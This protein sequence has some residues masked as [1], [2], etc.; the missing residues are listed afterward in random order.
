M[1]LLET[2][3]RASQHVNASTRQRVNASKHQHIN[4]SLGLPELRMLCW[5]LIQ[6]LKEGD[7]SEPE[8]S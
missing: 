8:S 6:I 5:F 2:C 1:R 4:V 7:Q 3:P